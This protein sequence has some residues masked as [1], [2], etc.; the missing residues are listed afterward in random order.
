LWTGEESVSAADAAALNRFI[1]KRT[2]EFWCRFWWPELMAVEKRFFRAEYT[3]GTAYVAGDEVYYAK[4]DRYYQALKGFTGAGGTVPATGSAGNYVLNAAYWAESEG[5]YSADDWS[6]IRTY[7]AGDIVYQPENG[8]F[9]GCHTGH[10]NQTPP[11]V[12]YWGELTAFRR[13]IEF[14]Q[15]LAD[16]SDATAIGEVKAIWNADPQVTESACAQSFRVQ[17]SGIVVRGTVNVVWVEFRTRVPNYEGPVWEEDTA[18]VAGDVVYFDEGEESTVGDYYECVLATSSVPPGS[19][20]GGYWR[21]L[22]FPYVLA[23]MVG[24]A[25]F[26]EMLKAD[27]QNDKSGAEM[28]EAMRLYALEIDKAERQ[29]GQIK[30]LNVKGRW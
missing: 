9:Y 2:R 6:A 5:E 7:V 12:S 16:G 11:N 29:Q 10:L 3:T 4:T 15:V 23:E 28:G 27:G 26:A 21:L 25:A 24:Q 13:E 22:E 30:Q 20:D 14:E 1:R 17:G 18:Y 8:K 19:D